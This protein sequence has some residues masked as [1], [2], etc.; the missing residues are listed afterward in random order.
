MA[1]IFKNKMLIK[2]DGE[3][4][5]ADT[6]LS[7]KKLICLYFAAQWCPP[8]RMF[9]PVL[10]NA[11]KDAKK[12]NLSIE[13][14]FMSGDQTVNDMM[15]HMRSS[16]GDWYA[17]RFADRL[18]SE[19]EERYMVP[20]VLT[21]LVLRHDGT[22]VDFNGKRLIQDHGVKAF[23]HWLGSSLPTQP[24]ETLPDA[25]AD[26]KCHCVEESSTA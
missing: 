1:D 2:K 6:V 13:V 24:R 25:A 20:G 9:T 3:Q 5:S 4:H 23:H 15:A 19:I 7:D 8:C 16:H 18:Q 26:G 21:L 14:I 22:V 12:E 10:T 17:L 11:Y